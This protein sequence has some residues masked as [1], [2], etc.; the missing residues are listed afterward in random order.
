MGRLKRDYTGE[1]RTVPL[2][3]QLTPSERLELQ[4]RAARAKR[5]I[6]D[7]LRWRE[8]GRPETVGV[9]DPDAVYRLERQIHKAGVNLNQISHHLNATHDLQ[10]REE[11]SVCITELKIA[12]ARVIALP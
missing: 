8:F 9:I 3:L 12:L 6:S 1:R 11:L 2:T 7:Y 10:S 5:K 4:S